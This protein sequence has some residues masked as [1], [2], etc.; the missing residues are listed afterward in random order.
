[1][2]YKAS[3]TCNNGHPVEWGSCTSVVKKRFGGTKTC[4]SKGFEQL[5]D[6]GRTAIVSFDKETW[7][8][9]RCLGC[10]AIFMSRK[11]PICDESVPVTAFRKKGLLAKLG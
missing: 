7:S 2:N 11:C 6:S 10:D 1:M 5:Y 8:A 3:A 9:V 4:G